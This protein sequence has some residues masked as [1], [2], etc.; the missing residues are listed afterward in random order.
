MSIQCLL[1]KCLGERDDKT[2]RGFV[3]GERG[4]GKEFAP[5]GK[6]IFRKT[7]GD[8]RIDNPFPHNCL[9]TNC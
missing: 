2:R 3:G 6:E 5:K 4:R 7:L 9:A 1:E 8:R